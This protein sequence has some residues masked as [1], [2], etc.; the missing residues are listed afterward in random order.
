MMQTYTCIIC[1][2]GC[3]LQVDMMKDRRTIKKVEGNLCPK[4]AEYARQEVQDP[5][6]TIAT[7]VLVQGG[8][9]PLASVRLSKAVPKNQIFDVMGAIKKITLQAPVQAGSVILFNVLDSGSDVI[10]TRSVKAG[11]QNV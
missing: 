4:G 7:S 5:R 10:V 2:N 6:R 1:P 11:G 3:E 8:V 9:L